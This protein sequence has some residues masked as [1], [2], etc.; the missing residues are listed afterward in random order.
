MSDRTPTP[1]KLLSVLTAPVR[2]L[3]VSEAKQG[4]LLIAVAAAALFAANSAF[5]PAYQGM[6]HNTLAWTPIPK[7]ANLHLWINDGL[8]AI[9]FFVVGL[10]VKREVIEGQLSSPSQRRL[11]VLAAIGEVSTLGNAD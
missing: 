5:A 4:I 11:P 2:A 7:L 8:M 9:F 1:A 6:F 10:E 3:F